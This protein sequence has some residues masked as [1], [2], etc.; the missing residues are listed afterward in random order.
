[1]VILAIESMKRQLL[2]SMLLALPLGL[3]SS[4]IFAMP[5]TAQEILKEFNLVVLGDANSTSHVDGRSYVAGNLSGGDYVQHPND[6]NSSAYAGLTV[7]GNASN[8]HV[9]GLGAVVGKDLS[10]STINSG[11]AVVLGKA[12]NDSFNGSAY[13]GTVGTGNNFNGGQ[14]PALKTGTAA[15]A[16]TS[17][18][19]ANV[20]SDFSNHIKALDSTGS[21]VTVNGNRATFNA[22]AG[23]NGVAVFN[24]AD[25][26]LFTSVIAEY[27]FNLNGATTVIINSGAKDITISANFLGGSAQAIGSKILW[28]FYDATNLTIT[29]QFGGSILASD[30]SFKNT[31]N[32]EG[33]VYVNT[34]NQQAEIHLQ[35]FT[36]TVPDTSPVP[37]P[38]TILLFGTGLAGLT[39]IIRRKK[40]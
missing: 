15:Q 19:F 25:S 2:R 27:A 1:M 39:G 7:Q 4:P 12:S 8:V 3:M 11:S 29:S 13:V 32:I 18:N 21:S 5:L 37:E 6:T 31:A 17:T 22:V 23:A 35:S 20:L 24:L 36:G 28:D 9:N 38:T 16:A 33:G 30:A 14:N 34:L 26:A 10:G 40:A